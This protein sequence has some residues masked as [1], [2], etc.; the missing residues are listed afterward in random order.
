MEEE[1]SEFWEVA[2]HFGVPDDVIRLQTP[3]SECMR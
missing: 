1:L 2:E 3:I